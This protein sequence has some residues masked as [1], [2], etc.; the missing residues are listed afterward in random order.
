MKDE[1]LSGPVIIRNRGKLELGKITKTYKRK[2]IRY[3]NVM[4]ERGILLEHL[5]TDSSFPCY[6]QPDFKR[7]A[8][9]LSPTTPNE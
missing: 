6:I 1:K 4:T 3:Y 8:D 2:K 7:L 9:T 5:T